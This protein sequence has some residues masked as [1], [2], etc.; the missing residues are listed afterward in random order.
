MDSSSFV[1]F[2]LV[3]GIVSHV[4]PFCIVIFLICK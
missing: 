2:Y 1:E 4:T 3:Y